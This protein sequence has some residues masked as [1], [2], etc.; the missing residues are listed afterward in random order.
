MRQVHGLV[1]PD[2][3]TLGGGG[4]PAV[5]HGLAVR[6]QGATLACDTLALHGIRVAH[7]LAQNV[8][9]LPR[10]QRLHGVGAL[11]VPIAVE[12]AGEILHHRPCGQHVQVHKIAGVGIAEIGIPQ[13][14]AP[15]DAHG[16]VGDEELVVHALLH[17]RKVAQRAEH[18]PQRRAPCPG[19]RVEHPHFDVGYKGQAH[20]LRIAAHAVK[21]V[22]QHPHTHA[23]PGCGHHTEQQA[24]G[25]GVGMDGVVLQVQR[26]L[27]GIY[28]R[29]AAAV[30]CLW[31][32]EQQE[33]RGVA[34]ACRC[35]A[36]LHELA[37]GRPCGGGQGARH[38]PLHVLG[39]AGAAAGCACDDDG[40][41]RQPA[42]AGR[43]AQKR[44]NGRGR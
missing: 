16:V 8:Q 6:C 40:Q 10:D 23:A 17:P 2:A 20:H 14:A 43:V 3:R 44:W 34:A 1:V 4:S 24:L 25:A 22:Q 33:P 37:Q 13:V 26:F 39:Q 28:Q 35:P 11:V 38:R 18:A 9:F 29:Q 41:K 32:T 5:L 36:I 27:R 7:A 12:T 31:P 15:G 21:I 30:G 42:V 19:E